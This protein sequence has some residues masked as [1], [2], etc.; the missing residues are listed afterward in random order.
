MKR[1]LLLLLLASV[2]FANSAETWRLIGVSGSVNE[3]QVLNDGG[4]HFVPTYQIWRHLNINRSERGDTIT[5][6]FGT[7]EL[8]FT[9]NSKKYWLNGTERNLNHATIFRNSINY[10]EITAFCNAMDA[11]TGLFFNYNKATREI[12]VSRTQTIDNNRVSGIVVLDPGHGGKD[13]GAIGPSGTHEK[14]VVLAI[15]LEVRKY[16]ER[17][18]NIKV[19]L[20]RETDVF[21]PLR[22]RSEFANSKNA[23]LFISIH[24]NASERSASVGG[25]KMYFLGEANNPYDEWTA[26]L[27]NSVLEL[28]GESSLS[29]LEAVLMSLANTE[30][31]RESQEFSIMLARSFERNVSGVQRLHTGVGQAN[32]FVLNWAA[33]PAA[34]I[35]VGFISNPREERLLRD[36]RFQRTAAE[37]IGAAIVEFLNK[38]QRYSGR[39]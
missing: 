20:T 15:A 25:F 31:I 36:R 27:E 2:L 32:F 23:D 8:R 24:A 3:I 11:L 12:R 18:P 34:L 21:V 10:S 39:R 7:N 13:P 16:L 26:R 1:I 19:H 28:E 6:R 33:M 4:N 38:S 29:G 35:E 22:Q 5:A 14:D 9:R 17:H 37:G 30:F